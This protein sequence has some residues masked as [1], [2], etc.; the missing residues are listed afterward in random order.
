MRILRILLI[1][2]KMDRASQNQN[3]WSITVKNNIKTNFTLFKFYNSSVKRSYNKKKSS[4]DYCIF[5]VKSILIGCNGK[6]KC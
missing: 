3:W 6:N 5:D 1:L 2:C 4:G